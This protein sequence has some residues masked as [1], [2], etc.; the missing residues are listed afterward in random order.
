MAPKA[1]V[2]LGKCHSGFVKAMIAK[3]E[4]SLSKV[5]CKLNTDEFRNPEKGVLGS[6]S[7]VISLTSL[8]SR[9]GFYKA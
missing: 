4:I 9:F 1:G 8:R 3:N 6:H 5:V 2:D 7:I